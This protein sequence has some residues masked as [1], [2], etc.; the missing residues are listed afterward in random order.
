MWLGTTSSSKRAAL[1]ILCESEDKKN[2]KTVV[3][4]VF[5]DE[6]QETK[7]SKHDHREQVME[8]YPKGEAPLYRVRELACLLYKYCHVMVCCCT[9]SCIYV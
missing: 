7:Q 3:R 1:F 8:I 6:V 2:S 4:K 5:V 9:S